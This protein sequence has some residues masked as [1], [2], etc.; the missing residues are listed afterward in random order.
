M[1]C[2][3]CDPVQLAIWVVDFDEHGW[4]G[5]CVGGRCNLKLFRVVPK[6]FLEK[7]EHCL[8]AGEKFSHCVHVEVAD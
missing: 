7:S 1:V 6:N 2:L 8:V 4:F 3:N 5:V